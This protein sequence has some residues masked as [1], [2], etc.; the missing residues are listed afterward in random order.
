[1]SK[2]LLNRVWVRVRVY[3]R[4]R[5]REIISQERLRVPQGG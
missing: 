5:A 3:G 2:I 1:M 4:L